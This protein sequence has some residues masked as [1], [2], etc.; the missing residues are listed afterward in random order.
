MLPHGNEFNSI[1]SN[2]F[3]KTNYYLKVSTERA[4]KYCNQFSQAQKVVIV[5][6]WR[7]MG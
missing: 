5:P 6:P 7:Y 4:G 2:E 1:K 3:N